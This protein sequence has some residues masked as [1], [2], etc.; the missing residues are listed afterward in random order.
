MDKF[1]KVFNKLMEGQ[2]DE[3][4]PSPFL[5][6]LVNDTDKQ[7]GDTDNIFNNT[8]ALESHILDTRNTHGQKVYSDRTYKAYQTLLN[9]M[10]YDEVKNNNRSNN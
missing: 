8:R 9:L 10:S 7:G 4:M 3:R 6:K 2:L 1:N 5:K